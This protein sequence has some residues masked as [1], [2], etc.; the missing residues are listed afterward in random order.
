[1]FTNTPIT[2]STY[3][4]YFGSIYVRQSYLTRYKQV[5]NQLGSRI[6]TIEEHETELRNLGLID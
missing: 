2:N 1:M 5:L 6:T 3:L 4:G